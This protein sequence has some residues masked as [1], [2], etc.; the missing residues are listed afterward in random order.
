VEAVE[1]VLTEVEELVKMYGITE[2]PETLSDAPEM[3]EVTVEVEPTVRERLPAVGLVAS[4]M[5]AMDPAAAV[6]YAEV[7]VPSVARTLQ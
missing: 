5:K 4:T 2:R 3:V 6:A 1:A 7:L